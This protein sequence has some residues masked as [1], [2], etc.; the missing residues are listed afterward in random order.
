MSKKNIHIILNDLKAAV[1]LG[2]PA[3]IQIA[4]EG[5]FGIPQVAANDRLEAALRAQLILPV[6]EILARRPHVELQPLLEHP[7]A[8]LRAISASALA[9]RYIWGKDVNPQVLRVP[10][11]DVRSDVRAALGETLLAAGEANPERLLPLMEYWL[12]AKSARLRET[13]LIF[14]PALAASHPAEIIAQL[15]P[16]HIEDDRAIRAALVAALQNLAEMGMADSVLA[17]LTRWSTVTQPNTWVI[18]RTLSYTWAAAYPRE[19]ADILRALQ[20]TPGSAKPIQQT[21]DAHARRG[22]QIIL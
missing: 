12:K 9:R 18:A 3:A 13:A 6:G 17:L 11:R 21:I 1:R 10:A 2:Q 20:A 16:L 8:A 7:T 19:L 22:V 14:I 4:L 5:L 15:E